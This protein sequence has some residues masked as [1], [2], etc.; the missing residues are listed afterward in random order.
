MTNLATT[1]DVVCSY[2]ILFDACF[3]FIEISLY[4]NLVKRFY[5]NRLINGDI[6]GT[7]GIVLLETPTCQTTHSA[8]I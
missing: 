3:F 7:V 2:S 4:K 8:L 1:V 5:L 6:M